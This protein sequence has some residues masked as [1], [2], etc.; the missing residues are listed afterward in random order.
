MADT[1][2]SK[3]IRLASDLPRGHDRRALLKVLAGKKLGMRL[4]NEGEDNS[5]G[6][7]YYPLPVRLRSAERYV[8]ALRAPIDHKVFPYPDS[9][10]HMLTVRADLRLV[11]M[12][13]DIMAL[14]SKLGLQRIQVNKPGE[15][16]FYFVSEPEPAA[17]R[18][19]QE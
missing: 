14:K 5:W 12:A 4:P 15:I 18:P 3:L 7:G 8:E 16:S 11:M 17:S 19:R 6:A 1:L 9:N 10:T 2:R 13:E